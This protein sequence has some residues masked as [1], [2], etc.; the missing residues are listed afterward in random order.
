MSETKT[1]GSSARFGIFWIEK[2]CSD[3]K[4]GMLVFYYTKSVIWC[5]IN[6]V[7]SINEIQSCYAECWTAIMFTIKI[8]DDENQNI[9]EA[10]I[11]SNNRFFISAA[12]IRVLK[13]IKYSTSN[14]LFKNNLKFPINMTDKRNDKVVLKFQIKVNSFVFHWCNKYDVTKF[15]CFC[16][17]IFICSVDTWWMG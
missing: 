9:F 2:C 12:F 7:I 5:W 17:P 6:H 10:H 15:L 3:F 16:I 14:S 11:L 4:I 13:S 1:S 8:F